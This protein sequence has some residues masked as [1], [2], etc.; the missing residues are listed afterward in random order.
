METSLI[1]HSKA[2][3]AKAANSTAFRLSTGKA[4]G[5]P[6][7]TGH[8]LVFGGSPKRVE[9]EQKIFDTVSSCTWTS[10][11]MTASYFASKSSETAGVVAI[12][13]D[14]NWRCRW[15]AV[16][17]RPATMLPAS[18]S[19]STRADERDERDARRSIV[20]LLQLLGLG[21][22]CAQVLLHRDFKI[23]EL[24]ALPVAD[25][26]QV[27]AGAGQRIR[28]V[29]DIKKQKPTC[30][31]MR[32]HGFSAKLSLLDFV[33]RLAVHS[34]FDLFSRQRN[35]QRIRPVVP[36]RMREP[37]HQIVGGGGEQLAAIFG[38][39]LGLH[40]DERDGL[41]T[42]IRDYE[43]DRHVTM[44]AVV[45]TED[46]SFVLDVIRIDCDHN[47]FQGVVI[48][49]GVGAGGLCRGHHK[50]F[51]RKRGQAAEQR[52]SADCRKMNN[53]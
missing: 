41:I 25:S 34:A 35:R 5:S 31:R 26:H 9:H 21:R 11:P 51:C 42:I 19:L 40:A 29:G 4:P 49:R 18:D 30:C 46:R 17:P 8:T 3:A 1:R 7:H 20:R 36:G 12:S 44:I 37:A 50:V 47:F 16:R 48:V 24:V 43:E 13:G 27:E 23:H 14:Y 6:R 39:Q 32:F 52:K 22:R 33:P 2:I 53:S 10:S 15:S 45:D 28:D 38:I